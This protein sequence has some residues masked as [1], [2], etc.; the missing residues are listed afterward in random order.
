MLAEKEMLLKYPMTGD[1]LHEDFVVWLKILKET[2]YA[3]A[4]DEPLLIYRLSQQSKSSDKK[5]AAWMTWQVY[6]VIGLNLVESIYYFI[7]YT[8]KNIK[9]YKKIRNGFRKN[10]NRSC[11]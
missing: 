11:V 9:K 6:R 5:K 3:F 2:K 8:C 7:C 1:F 4:V 10:N